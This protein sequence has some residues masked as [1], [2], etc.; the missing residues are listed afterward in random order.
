MLDSASRRVVE[1]DLE[2][3]HQEELAIA[4]MRWPAMRHAEKCTSNQR[5]HSSS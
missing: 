3:P 5:M 4:M 2:L 1:F